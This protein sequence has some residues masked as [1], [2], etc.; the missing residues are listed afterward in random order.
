MNHSVIQDP[1]LVYEASSPDEVALLN[2]AKD[3]GFS[4][5]VNKSLSF[6]LINQG[7]TSDT[8]EVEVLGKQLRFQLLNELHFTPERVRY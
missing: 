5:T 1:G 4:F 2:G 8:L 6:A 3:I 7:R